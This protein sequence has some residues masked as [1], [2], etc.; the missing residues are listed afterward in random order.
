MAAV[1]ESLYII[2][3]SLVIFQRDSVN[4]TEKDFPRLEVTAS[5]SFVY[6]PPTLNLLFYGCWVLG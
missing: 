6:F 2:L 5:S 1:L 3:N 4:G